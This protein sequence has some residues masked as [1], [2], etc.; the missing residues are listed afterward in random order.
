[1]SSRYKEL[2][3]LHS[4]DMHGDFAAE[5][6][7]EK[8]LGGVSMLSG[9]VM[10]ARA[11][12]PNT[13]Y[14]VA[15]DML[16]GSL[17][18]TEFR[19]ISTIEIMNILSPDIACLGNHEIDYGL[20][21]LMFLERC[22]KFPVVCANLF[23]RRPYTRLFDSHEIVDLDGMKVLFIGIVTEEVL[24][25]IRQDSLLGTL[26]D[27]EDAAEEIGSICDAYRSLD[28]D[29]TVLLT[30][31]GF[32]EDKKLAALLDPAWGV[33]LIIGGHSHTLL[34][35]PAEV[36]GVLIAQAAV[37]TAQIGRFD[38]VVDTELDCVHSF[39][40]KLI[41][42]ESSHCPR[43]P[44][45]EEIVLGFQK[46][47]NEKYDCMLC[48]FH[49]TLSHPDRNQETELGNLFADALKDS[50]GVD[51]MI[52]GSG[53]IRKEKVDPVFTRGDL[54]E[55]MPYD[56]RIFALKV[57]GAQ[58]RRMLAFMLREENLDG[59]HGEFYQFSSGLNV[60]Y[61]RAT[62]EFGRFDFADHRLEDAEVLRIGIQEYHYRSFE[63]FFGFALGEL[64]DGRGL[65]IATSLQ[66]VLEEHFSTARRPRAKVE[67][68]LII[69]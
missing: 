49:R 13:L 37:G 60:T 4:N 26:I 53:S 65:V 47:V 45:L 64:V 19:G 8:L 58:L 11:D 9:Y 50:L 54:L 17:I 5:Q 23:V 10:K 14:C 56:D 63:N 2:T 22:A 31:I 43:D 7:D 57:T 36:N 59:S 68:R 52:V 35:E 69:T 25:S 46:L 34:T 1:M 39:E 42:I 29:L 38:L 62:K 44:E 48:R 15:G 41:P 33:D 66:D 30:H 67:G 20:G 6:V 24:N 32:E 12:N 28:I 3:L 21:H 61:D 16:Q 18:D 55:V 27:V 51:L 40:W